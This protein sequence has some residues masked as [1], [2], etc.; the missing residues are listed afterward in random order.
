MSD[1]CWLY[2]A[3]A[4]VLS[5]SSSVG[6]AKSARRSPPSADAAPYPALDEDEEDEDESE[7]EDEREDEAEPARLRDAGGSRGSGA[8]AEKRPASFGCPPGPPPLEP[9]EPRP[10]RCAEVERAEPEPELE[11][12]RP[13]EGR[14]DDDDEDDLRCADE[15]RDAPA[16]EKSTSAIVSVCDSDT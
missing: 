15:A 10:L 11:M 8:Y 1:V 2:L 16:F 7:R 14:D 5:I 4:V 6:A 9:L 3:A 12:E 13:E